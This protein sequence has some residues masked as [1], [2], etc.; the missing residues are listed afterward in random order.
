MRKL[1]SDESSNDVYIVT[2]EGGL[3][4]V[5]KPH[6]EVWA[7]NYRAEVLAYEL[8]ELFA[9]ERVP[10]TVKRQEHGQVGSIQLFRESIKGGELAE[11][12]LYMQSL[13]DF[14]I[15]QRDRY[16]RNYLVS[17]EKT[18]VSIDNGVGL[19]GKGGS[20]LPDLEKIL[21]GLPAFRATEKG[22]KFLDNVRKYAASRPLK[23]EVSAYL[24]AE[25]AQNLLDRMQFIIKYID[26]QLAGISKSLFL[27][28]FVSSKGVGDY[29][30]GSVAQVVRFAEMPR[31]EGKKLLEEIISSDEAGDY[32]LGVAALAIREAK[33]A[34]VGSEQLL[35]DILSS[36]EAGDFAQTHVVYAVSF[37][38][39]MPTDA[40]KILQAVIS[41]PNSGAYSVDR[42]V[43][44]LP[45]LNIFE[46]DLLQIL[47]SI[48]SLQEINDLALKGANL[49]IKKSAFL[50][51][52]KELQMLLKIKNG[53]EL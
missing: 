2:L 50:R 35:K 26:S 49:M 7:S 24:G 18:I 15:D 53:D 22:K 11:F 28:N 23:E 47:K 29:G 42:V 13:F 27:K 31:V 5:W 52:D 37:A 33:G 44:F 34:I 21:Q 30:L 10:I 43:Y 1:P 16:S 12:E 41:S 19:S 38:K 20:Y 46:Q 4:G 40:I 17:L 3:T 25:E 48:L 45:A 51:N 32:A 14:I 39:I 36:N 9:Y 6:E 8:S